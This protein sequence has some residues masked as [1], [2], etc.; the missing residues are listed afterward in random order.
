MKNIYNIFIPPKILNNPE[1][2]D[3]A[4]LI[5]LFIIFLFF[6]S[7]I[8]SLIYYLIGAREISFAVLIAG[9]IAIVIPTILKWS[10]SINLA[11]NLMVFDL[12]VVIIMVAYFTGGQ[13]TFVLMWLVAIPMLVITTTNRFYG[14]LWSGL[15]IV[16]MLFSYILTKYEFSFPHT[17]SPN[18]FLMTNTLIGIGLICLVLSLSWIFEHQKKIAIK[19]ALT[20]IDSEKKRAEELDVLNQYLET[21]KQTLLNTQREL[22]KKI[23]DLERVNKIM[24]NRELN[25]IK[26]K[27]EINSYLAELGRDPKYK[28]MKED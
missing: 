21:Q 19:T 3:Q 11:A 9:C 2:T 7:P 15:V 13:S 8:F 17:I 6:W 14:F 18:F 28:A 1:Q 26:L 20:S 22:D 24:I 4:K 16:V 25:M 10:E 5:L 27:E 12:F 23:L